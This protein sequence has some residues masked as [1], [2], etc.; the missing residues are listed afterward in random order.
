MEWQQQHQ[1]VL[2]RTAAL[3]LQPIYE[4]SLPVRPTAKVCGT[5]LWWPQL[6]GSN[7]LLQNQFATLGTGWFSAVRGRNAWCTVVGRHNTS[8]A[9]VRPRSG[10][11]EKQEAICTSQLHMHVRKKVDAVWSADIF[12]VAW[13]S[14]TALLHTC[15]DVSSKELQQQYQASA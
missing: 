7:H 12:M 3:L 14:C 10:Q 9:F 4:C 11:R 5:C 13:L 8:L 1:W 15:C 2:A 6:G